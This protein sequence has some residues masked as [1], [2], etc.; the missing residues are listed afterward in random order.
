MTREQGL[1]E[2]TILPSTQS[3]MEDDLDYVLK[4]LDISRQEWNSI[5]NAPYKTEDD[6]PN[7]KKLVQLGMRVKHIFSNGV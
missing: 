5:L 3:E 1:E 2:L 6:Y 7:Y 4:K